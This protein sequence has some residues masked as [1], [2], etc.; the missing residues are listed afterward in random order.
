MAMGAGMTSAI[1]NPVALPITKIKIA[2]KRAAVEAAGISVPA[3]MA[4][5]DFVQIFGL[6][7]TLSRAGKEMEAIRAAN[8]LTNNDPHGAEWIR[9]N[10][11]DDERAASGGRGGR[12]GG[13]RRRG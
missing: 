13:R 1:M 5:E 8:L 12:S 7:S 4:D 9:F 3:D 6:G 11:S 10:K 2:E